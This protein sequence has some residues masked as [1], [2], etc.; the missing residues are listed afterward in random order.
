LFDY[1]SYSNWLLIIILLNLK[2]TCSWID[3]CDAF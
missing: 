3:H 2:P 1:I